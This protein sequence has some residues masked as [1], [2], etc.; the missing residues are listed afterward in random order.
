MK[1]FL[2]LRETG[3]TRTPQRG[4]CRICGKSFC[5]CAARLSPFNLY[6]HYKRGCGAFSDIGLAL[7][8]KEFI[9]NSS[10]GPARIFDR[11]GLPVECKN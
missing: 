1:A 4:P 5:D 7:R 2:K 11:Y 10:N 9:D 3:E 8:C 6:D